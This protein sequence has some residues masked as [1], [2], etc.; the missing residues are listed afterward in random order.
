MKFKQQEDFYNKI[1]T[2]NI[3]TDMID[4]NAIDWEEI[5]E[6]VRKEEELNNS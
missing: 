5:K 2:A 4:F 1:G 6:S 3:Y